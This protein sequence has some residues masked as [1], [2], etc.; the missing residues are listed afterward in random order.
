MRVVKLPRV[1]DY[2]QKNSMYGLYNISDYM[3]LTQYEI[4]KAYFHVFKISTIFHSI[5]ELIKCL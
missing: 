1:Y 4:I 3:S 5:T 2:W